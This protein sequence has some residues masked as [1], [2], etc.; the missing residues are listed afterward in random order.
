MRVLLLIALICLRAS[1]FIRRSPVAATEFS[2]LSTGRS[3]PTSVSA[4]RLFVFS[5][6]SL[7]C[8]Q[9]FLGVS[10]HSPR[11]FAGSA[12]QYSKKVRNTDDHYP[13]ESEINRL[14][15]F[16]RL[17]Q[18]A[19]R[20]RTRRLGDGEINRLLQSCSALA[21]NATSIEGASILWSI[22]TLKLSMKNEVIAIGLF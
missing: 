11:H 6:F 7:S 22:G 19:T 15:S 21:H 13:L 8:H 3:H 2:S 9:P 16:A 4:H 20:S 14:S 5:S 12:L 17:Q 1:S 18:F 10:A